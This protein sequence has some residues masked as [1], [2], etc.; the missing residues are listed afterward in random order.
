MGMLEVSERADNTPI[1]ATHIIGDQLSP[2]PIVEENQIA[3]RME[4]SFVVGWSHHFLPW[5][6][7]KILLAN[8][9]RKGPLPAVLG[10]V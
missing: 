4:S 9:A 6:K 3:V 8:T 5:L 1:I 7:E 10:P 2:R